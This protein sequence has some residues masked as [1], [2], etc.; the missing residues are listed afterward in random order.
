MIVSLIMSP[1]L[2]G[3]R[4]AAQNDAIR[5]QPEKG[6]GP[7]G[8]GGIVC[9]DRSAETNVGYPTDH[10][11]RS[12]HPPAFVCDGRRSVASASSGAPAVGGHHSAVGA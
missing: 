12:Q 4:W 9:D 7:P 6:R 5:Q 1:R 8:H 10:K 3:E 2:L 11:S